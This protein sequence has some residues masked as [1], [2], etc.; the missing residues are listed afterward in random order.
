YHRTIATTLNTLIGAGFA[1]RQIEEF[2]PTAAQIAENADLA[3]EIERPM[4]VL[5]SAQ[6]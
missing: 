3:E 4:M 5:V 6:R 1:I 2:A